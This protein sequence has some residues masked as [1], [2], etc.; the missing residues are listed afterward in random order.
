MMTAFVSLSLTAASQKATSV[1]PLSA[2]P[3]APPSLSAAPKQMVAGPSDIMQPLT[4]SQVKNIRNRSKNGVSSRVIA[5]NV[6]D[7]RGWVTWPAAMLGL[8]TLPRTNDAQFTP[9]GTGSYGIINGGGYDDGHGTYHGVYY[10]LGSEG[11][12]D[13]KMIEFNSETFDITGVNQLDPAVNLGIVAMDVDIDPT[14][15][16]VYGC[17]MTDNGTGYCWGRGDYSTATRT[18]LSNIDSSSRMVAVGCDAAGQYYALTASSMLVKVDKQT[19]ATTT[20]GQT[21]VPNEGFLAGYAAGG[22]VDR[23]NNKMYVT[24]ITPDSESGIYVV[25]LATAESAPAV[26]FKTPAMVVAPFFASSAANIVPAA[27]ELT[28]SAPEGTLTVSFTIALPSKLE[29]GQP[30]TG[31]LDWELFLDGALIANGSKEAGQTVT[32]TYTLSAPAMCQFTATVANSAGKSLAASTSAFIGNGLPEAPAN[33]LASWE[34]GKAILTWDAVTATTDGGYID[35]AAV[36]YT[37]RLGDDIIAENVTST[38]YEYQ[39]A[40]PENRQSYTYSVTAVNKGQM[41]AAAESN[42]LWLGSLAV[43]FATD[44]S[45]LGYYDTIEGIGYT[46]IDA[47]DDKCTWGPM[48][49]GKGIRYK[50]SSSNAADDWVITPPLRLEA[51]KVYNF[52]AFV[53]NYGSSDEERFEVKAG[54]GDTAADMTLEVIPA[55]TVNNVAGYYA[56]GLIVPTTTGEW[57]VG[58]HCISDPYKYYLIVRE[59]SIGKGMFPTTPAAVS[60][61]VLTPEASGLLEVSGKFKMPEVDVTGKALGG[62]V[63]VKISRGDEFV[64]TLTGAPGEQ[65]SFTDK[66][67]PAKGDYSYTVTTM[68]G[69]EEGVSSI[70]SVFV[71]PHAASATTKVEVVETEQ[72]GTVTVKWEPVATDI[73]GNAISAGNVTYMV[74]SVVGNGIFD[75]TVTPLL[76]TPTSDTSATVKVLSDPSVQQFIQIS[77]TAYNRD[78]ESEDCVSDMVAVGQ[79]YQMPVT[80]SGSASKDKYIERISRSGTGF[81]ELYDDTKLTNAPK[82]VATDDYYGCYAGAAELYG[83]LYTGKID[84]T[85]AEHPEVA[86]YTYKF[87]TNHD[88]FMGED[89]NFIQ[90]IALA[91]NKMTL[92]GTANHTDMAEGRWNKVRMDLS[93]FKGKTVQLI[94]RAVAKSGKYTLLDEAT[95]METP[96]RDLAARYLTAPEQCVASESFDIVALVANDGYETSSAAT[97]KLFRNGTLAEERRLDALAPGE[98]T[99]VTFKQQISY[100]DTDN[101]SA[102]Y[103][104]EIVMTG[105]EVAVNNHFESVEVERL[106]M[107]LPAVTDLRGE[108]VGNGNRLTW[109]KYS[110]ETLEP[111]EITEG[112]EEATPWKF[113]YA[114]WTFL[115]ENNSAVANIY[116]YQFPGITAYETKFAW[117]VINNLGVEDELPSAAGK[118]YIASLCKSNKE[119]NNDWAI[120]PLLFGEAQKISFQAKGVRSYYPEKF[121]VYYTDKDSTDPADYI[122]ISGE[123]PVITSALEWEK[124]EYNLPGGALH[125]AVRCVSADCY[126]L[127]LD[128]F[129]FTPDPQAGAPVL[130]GYDVYRDGVKL[131]DAPVAE[132]EYVDTTPTG[133][134]TYHVVAKYDKGVSELSNPVTLN[135][136]GINIEEAES[137]RVYADGSD[138]VVECAPDAE[139]VVSTIDGKVVYRGRGECRISAT[140]TVYIVT[141]N[142]KPCKLVIR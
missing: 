111:V 40:V 69:S 19:G 127:M 129:V 64:T 94:F 67:I 7:L 11:V 53:S 78:A 61:I 14:S 142:S 72:P 31:Q 75:T 90:V 95:V 118:Q 104:A 114:D 138:I 141:I 84:L 99:N 59:L 126:F 106:I 120:S 131:N 24:Y 58:I 124:F 102:T 46:V 34:N 113:E 110:S 52:S 25:D 3:K 10:E 33:V 116:G 44:F 136:S 37:I 23:E 93:E 103:T 57:N 17:Y 125:F 66:A 85:D 12:R 29:N 27:P 20:V 121:E 123:E 13:L 133:S 51:G 132:A 86:F 38:K 82:P 137:N 5:D 91:D 140:P 32:G 47:N 4:K 100:F 73:N 122:K 9:V 42:M 87:P 28:I 18:L 139:V 21:T 56:S 77:V 2:L 134:H 81:W 76:D 55:T 45:P 115:S 80:Y 97:V 105:D 88:Y 135:F 15:G 50:Y 49:M 68:L 109:T 92:V 108:A 16:N 128:E 98:V 107:D 112:F 130:E 22:A 8:Y 41:S 83:D 101:S 70:S 1:A 6:P 43:P 89:T 36:T 48:G 39:L 71:G 63:T 60:D 54:M 65:V 96:A 119:A 35:P 26:D 30:A 62:N 79:P 117:M 74:Y